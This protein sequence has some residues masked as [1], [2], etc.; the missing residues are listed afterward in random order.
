VREQGRAIVRWQASCAADD[1]LRRRIARLTEDPVPLIR[2]VSRSRRGNGRP[3]IV[4]REVIAA[5]DVERGDAH[6]ACHEVWREGSSR[7][8]AQGLYWIN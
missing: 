2:G 3:C 6:E 4:C 1:A 7:D 8:A 5:S